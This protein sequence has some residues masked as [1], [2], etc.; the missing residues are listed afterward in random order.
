MYGK[1]AWRLFV[2]VVIMPKKSAARVDELT[3]KDL[4]F[5]E[6]YL[7]CWNQARAYMTAHPGTVY[8]TAC[9]NGNLLLKNTK[10]R[11]EI[12]KRI[13]NR[14]GREEILERLVMHARADIDDFLDV[15]V[16]GHTRINLDKAPLKRSVIK[17][18]KETSRLSADGE[19]TRTFRIEL[20]DAQ[21][22]LDKLAKASGLYDGNQK[23]KREL[24]KALD[25]LES[26]LD[27]ETYEK[28]LSVL[29]PIQNSLTT[30]DQ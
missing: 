20:Y 8:S 14:V 30:G 17:N 7:Q 2:C 22:A 6:A 19:L 12:D 4:E 21:A 13:K 23:T 29:A 27:S 3:P 10:V 24:E 9:T 16:N 28:V 11:A 26:S 5:I 25:A 1:V 18:I 15:D